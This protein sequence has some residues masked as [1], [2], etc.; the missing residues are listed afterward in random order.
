MCGIF[1]VDSDGLC[2]VPSQECPWSRPEVGLCLQPQKELSSGEKLGLRKSPTVLGKEPE[3]AEG[4]E[5][6][7]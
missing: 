4:S 2:D 7:V 6:L 5:H 1:C 3:G